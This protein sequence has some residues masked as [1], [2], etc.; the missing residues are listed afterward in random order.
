LH[1]L[2]DGLEKLAWLL[3]SENRKV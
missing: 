1:Q 2:I 3:K